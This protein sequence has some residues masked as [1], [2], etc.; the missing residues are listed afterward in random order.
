MNIAIDGHM[1][2][3]RESGN[4]TYALNL[5]RGLAGLP[6]DGNHYAVLT[7]RPQALRDRVS[8]PDDFQI[9]RVWPATSVLR[10]PLGMP[11][12]IRAARCDLLH[13]TYIA[14]PRPGCPTIVTVH[15][16]SYLAHPEWLSARV[17]FVLSTLVARSVRA[18]ARV[19]AISDFTKQDLVAR[20]GLAP[21]KIAVVPLAAGVEFAP[22]PDAASRPLPGGVREPFILGVGNLEPRK[23]LAT[24][25]DAFAEL[26]RQRSFAGQLVIAGKAKYRSQ[27]A[28][29]AVARLGLEDRVVFT[30][31]VD[32]ATLRIL[33]NRAAL[34][35]Y[36]SLYEGFGLPLLEAMASGCPVVANQA[37]AIPET[38]GDAAILVDASSAAKLAQAMARVLG[39]PDLA[40]GLSRKGLARASMFSWLRTAELTRRV[41]ED[42]LA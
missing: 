29:G 23:N 3:E 35:V 19:I 22:L 41:Y 17:R 37:T 6:A 1:I 28:A 21:D 4:E 42:A 25:I 14:P 2:G 32:D 30:G 27:E 34:F 36:P 16:L 15:D 10:I 31:F 26:V 9:L 40:R 13:V 7:P 39:D 24:L 11:L 38:A 8:L 18:A 33:Y 20:Y 5:L 12:A